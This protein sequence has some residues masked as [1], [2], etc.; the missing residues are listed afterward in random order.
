[1]RS[2]RMNCSPT[3]PSSLP[4]T[5]G[6]LALESIT[7]HHRAGALGAQLQVPFTDIGAPPN[8]VTIPCR[9]PSVSGCD[10]RCT[11]SIG[12]ESPTKRRAAAGISA[13]SLR[14]ELT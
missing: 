3:T 7:T 4:P 2:A 6:T 5:S 9:V 1:M 14:E 12:M 13:G 8:A 11:S 10:H